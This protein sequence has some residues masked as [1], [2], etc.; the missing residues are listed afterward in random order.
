[1]TQFETTSP[2][3]R[4]RRGTGSELTRT[5]PGTIATP[6]LAITPPV[7]RGAAILEQTLAVLAASGR[8]AGT[9]A[10]FLRGQRYDNE[11]EAA[12]AEAERRRLDAEAE[13]Y[14]RGLAGKAVDNDLPRDLGSIASGKY[15]GDTRDAAEIASSIIDARTKGQP[16]AWADQYDKEY[17]RAFVEAIVSRRGRIAEQGRAQLNEA[18]A[19]HAMTADPSSIDGLISDFRKVNPTSTDIDARSAIVVP[20]LKLAAQTG[21]AERVSALSAKL[22][23]D[24][25]AEKAKANADLAE[26]QARQSAKAN[27]DF[28]DRIAA[29]RNAGAPAAE[30]ESQI[31]SGSAGIDPN[32]VEQQR[33]AT[34]AYGQQKLADGTVA[35]FK[36]SASALRNAGRPA[37]E[38]EASIRAGGNAPG[39][40][41][42]MVEDELNA[43]RVW[44][45][46]RKAE[47][48]QAA[49]V[50]ALQSAQAAYL[51]NA[52]SLASQ[53][54]LWAL[55]KPGKLPDGSGIG[56]TDDDAKRAVIEQEFDKIR[57]STP[58]TLQQIRQQADFLQKNSVVYDPWKSTMEAGFAASGP[59]S[60][61]G[62]DE[63]R[64]FPPQA[65]AGFTLFKQVNGVAPGVVASMNLDP[66]AEKF[67]RLAESL[68]QDPAF[69]GDD[70]R[71]LREA[72]RLAYGPGRGVLSET[73]EA[74]IAME[75]KSIASRWWKADATNPGSVSARVADLARVYALG[76]TDGKTAVRRAAEVVRSQ[77]TWI[78]SW[79][80]P[81][82]QA[83]LPAELRNGGI[84]KAAAI[85]IGDYIKAVPK[86]LYEADDLTL[87]VDQPSGLVFLAE[88]RTGNVVPSA[89]AKTAFSMRELTSLIAKEDVDA[90]TIVAKWRVR[91][92]TPVG[93]TGFIS[94]F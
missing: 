87:I 31:A 12:K 75:S 69:A 64:P 41:P 49:K 43:T 2:Y 38:I 25:A 5:D 53:G 56:V 76:G 22:G 54:R 55:E 20:A 91:R 1:M 68:Q 44:D 46:A 88:G 3:D 34:R 63:K 79:L 80:Q 15:D 74:Q 48:A 14:D 29:L 60:L 18:S 50:Q 94:G 92:N 77:S 28:S 26:Y 35:A 33:V 59:A 61:I 90:D 30:I 51:S 93:P 23:D 27:A 4:I 82:G 16:G 73:K 42:Q 11:R 85:A 83:A 45:A 78:G 81:I 71:A 24:F 21:N 58:D 9:A 8:A 19:R 6:G 40:T 67:Y 84:D 37:A 66:D 39:I 65:V 62:S 36:N 32:T 89:Q 7:S 10:D 57:K 72:A 70:V 47:A 13:R 52:A 86:G 17:R